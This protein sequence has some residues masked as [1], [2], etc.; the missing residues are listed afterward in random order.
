MWYEPS[1]SRHANALDGRAGELAVQHRLLDA[2]VDGGPEAL[3]DDAADDLVH[4]LVALVP[5]ERLEHDVAVAELAAPA[6]LLLVA[7]CARDSLRI[8]SRYGTRGW[9]SSTSTPKRRCSRSTATSTCIWLIPDRS[10]SPVCGSRR[11][12]KRRVLLGEAPQRGRH[13]LLVALR[14]RGDGEAHH[15]LGEA[16][17]RQLD[18]PARC[19]AGGRPSARPS[20]SRPR[21]C[22]PR[23]TLR[24]AR[25]PCPAAGASA[26]TRSLPCVRALTSVESLE[27]PLEHAEDV[28]PAG[29]RVGDRL[30]D[31]R[32]RR[33][34][35]RGR[36]ARFFAGDGTPSTSRSSSAFVPRFF[37][38]TPQATGN[39]SPRVTASLR[40][41][42]TSSAPSSWPSR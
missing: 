27:T 40:A 24:A 9:C 4:E 21:R 23:R 17:R 11:S 30:E 19:R 13:L 5:L 8:V 31:E 20:A 36:S 3:R 16:D 35:R 1:T 29:E 41:C 7:P 6:G 33:R 12:T 39:T 18:G 26:P 10:C 32:G 14:L 38:A 34:A 42:A 2:L 25:A 15:G 22:R 37:V 28:D